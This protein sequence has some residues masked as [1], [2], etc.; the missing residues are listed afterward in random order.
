VQ[1]MAVAIVDELEKPQH[2]QKRF[3]VAN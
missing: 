3:T 2:I 1:D